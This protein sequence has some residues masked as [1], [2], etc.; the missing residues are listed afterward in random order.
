MSI[1]KC[2]KCKGFVIK[3]DENPGDGYTEFRCLHCGR[4]FYFEYKKYNRLVN[5][6]YKEGAMK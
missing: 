4:G 3:I 2:K 6:L 5:A 1:I